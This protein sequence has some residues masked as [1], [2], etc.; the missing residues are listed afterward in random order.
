MTPDTDTSA[1]ERRELPASA[2]RAQLERILSS[3]VF[4]RSR[5]LRRFLSFIVEQRL[6][7]QGHSLK[8]SVLAHELYGKGTDF[9]GGTDPVVRVDARRL[10]DKLREYY[11]GRTDPVV[12][13][14]P[15]GSY[16]PAF[17]PLAAPAIDAAPPAVPLEPVQTPRVAH[18]GRMKIGAGA[19]AVVAAVIAGALVWRTLSTPV[20]APA[21]L[22][23]LASYPGVEVTPALSADG[24]LVAFAW[25]GGADA[26]PT[27]I[28]IKAVGS[29]ALRQLTTT[30]VSETGPAWSPDGYNIAFVRDGQ[31]VFTMSQLGG[32]ERQVSASGTHVAWAGDSK[33]VLIR[34]R[35]EST[36]PFGIYQVFLDTL[37]RRRLTQAPVGA[38]DWRFEV[39][40][41]GRTL[42]FIRYEKAGIADLYV[43]PMA[44]GEP[45]RLSNW[46]AAIEGLSWT[47]DGQE[48]VYSV[49]EPAAS[50]LWRIAVDSATP[51]RGSA[52]SDLPMAA[53]NPT[54]SRPMP[55]QPA[56]L[57]FQTI[58]LDIDLQLVDLDATTPHGT[59]D[60]RPV[61]NSTRVEGS[62]RFS[63]DGARIAFASFRSGAPEVWV[64]DRDGSGV[65]Q[66]TTLGAAGILIGEWSPDG[67]RIAFEAA[68]DGNSDVYIVGADGGHLRRLTVEPSIE[69]VPAWS[70]DAQWIYFASTR[71]AAIP[72]I[73]RVSPNGG[74][75]IRVTHSGGF[76]PRESPDGR[77]LYY[78]DR[79]PGGAP[80][81]ARLMRMPLAGGHA[82]PVLEHVRPFLW[83]VT[84]TGIAFVTREPDFDA[85]DAYR[86]SDGRTTRVGRLEF[87]IPTRYTHMTVSRDG[88]WALATKMERF[89]SDLMR[90]DKFR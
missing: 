52:I 58:T 11:E 37:E 30:P 62:A 56:R 28:Y 5:Q 9:D 8:E 48:I 78:L 87:R 60:S 23:P 73:W 68:T 55:G 74:E 57:A 47:P 76:E 49:D 12:I 77:H 18:L 20:S 16:V 7:G 63:P 36:R 13:S 72:D 14:L 51:G 65:R 10:R 89:D 50:R 39:S 84:H 38:G 33:S 64:A 45:R 42:A 25:S 80:I 85:I 26:G 71:A 1:Q 79:H 61:L 15:K 31:G 66:L 54:I 24:N 53:W 43:V 21:E 81:E 59:L 32:A 6:A 90:F 70:H 75:P 44:G 83:S 69:G 67:T 17:E 3:P 19:V 34:D 82:E 86:S 46:N 41:D 27:D 40:P 29:E 88:R 22:L 4:S 35:E 2:V